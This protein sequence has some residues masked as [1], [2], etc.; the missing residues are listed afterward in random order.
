MNDNDLSDDELKLKAIVEFGSSYTY[1]IYSGGLGKT[2]RISAETKEDA[3]IIRKIAPTIW[4]NISV[5]VVY[6]TNI[7]TSED[8][9]E[10]KKLYDPKLK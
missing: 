8:L 1:E 10:N 4:E 3:T 6:P 2:L 5:I 9:E 7:K